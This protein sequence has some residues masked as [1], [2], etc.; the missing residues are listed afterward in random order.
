MWFERT[1]EDERSVGGEVSAFI[2]EPITAPRTFS[3]SDQMHPITFRS[4]RGNIN[5]PI[6]QESQAQKFARRT[7][8]SIV[9][10]LEKVGSRRK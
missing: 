10:L 8:E 1:N 2:L 4:S 5:G 9:F 3:R 6:V 7:R